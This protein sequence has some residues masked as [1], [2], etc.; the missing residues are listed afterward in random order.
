MVNFSISLILLNQL[1][2]QKDWTI[3]PS[4]HALSWITQL[5][6]ISQYNTLVMMLNKFRVGLSTFSLIRYFYFLYP[7]KYLSH[8]SNHYKRISIPQGYAKRLVVKCRGKVKR[9]YWQ[10]LQSFT[11]RF[12]KPKGWW[13]IETVLI[14]NE[15]RG[16]TNGFVIWASIF[17][18][19]LWLRHEWFM[20]NDPP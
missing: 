8:K 13:Y 11:N 3:D 2:H 6:K 1:T 19:S 20:G 16:K 12:P 17:E 10:R 18:C 7:I 15:K 9:G 14:S 5:M 4:S